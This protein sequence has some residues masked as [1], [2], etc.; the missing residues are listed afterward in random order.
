[1]LHLLARGMSNK[2]IAHSLNIAESTSK[3]HTA[4]VLRALGVRNRTEAAIKALKLT[5][6][7]DGSAVNVNTAT[8]KS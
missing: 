6:M 2:E 1:V 4:A 7:E 8:L 5:K 3:I